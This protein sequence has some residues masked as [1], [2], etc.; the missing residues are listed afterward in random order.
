MRSRSSPIA[1]VALLAACQTAAAD[2]AHVQ[3]H[4][5][6]SDPVLTPGETQT[7]EL[8]WEFKGEWTEGFGEQWFGAPGFMLAAE[9]PVK[10]YSCPG[11]LG[12]LLNTKNGQTGAFG[13]QVF[14]GQLT[15]TPGAVSPNNDIS[16]IVGIAGLPP[17]PWILTGNPVFLWKVDWTPTTFENRTVAFDFMPGPNTWAVVSWEYSPGKWGTGVR[18]VGSAGDSISF[19]VVPAPATVFLPALASGAV[20]IRRRR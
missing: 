18:K 1:V 10:Y 2:L 19:K 7:I 17:S 12:D 9:F 5:K 15:G 11:F 6:I 4:L 16:Y 20:L 3:Y 8:W 13:Q 14:N